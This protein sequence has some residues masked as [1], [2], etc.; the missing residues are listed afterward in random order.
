M[1]VGFVDFFEL[2]FGLL[3]LLITGLEVRMV[4]AGQLAIGFLEFVVGR[5]A[6]D[7]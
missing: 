6:V 7:A 3:F 1:L 5:V 2:L 4:L